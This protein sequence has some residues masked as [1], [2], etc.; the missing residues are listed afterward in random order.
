MYPLPSIIDTPGISRREAKF[1]G[2]LLGLAARM[3]LL[4]R[5][6]AKDIGRRWLRRKAICV[7]TVTISPERPS[8]KTVH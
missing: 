5:K 8:H 4:S 2:H 7:P 1:A 3:G 6:R